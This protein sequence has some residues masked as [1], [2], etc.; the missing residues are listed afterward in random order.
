[1][2]CP[3]GTA[4]GAVVG[5]R[6]LLDSEVSG[7]TAAFGM[8]T[9]GVGS[10]VV[11]N[12]IFWLALVISIPLNGYNPY[13]GFAALLGVLLLAAFSASVYL[14]TKGQRHAAD[15]LARVAS[16]VPFVNPDTVASLVQK[17][18]DRVQILL[19]RPAPALP[20][21]VVGRRELVG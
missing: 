12:V 13:Y 16:H 21:A 11:L 19:E 9:Q 2:S 8:A 18:A 14:L 7:S 10:A 5:Y 1:M 15:W 20:R 4:P 3:G 6:Q 17:V